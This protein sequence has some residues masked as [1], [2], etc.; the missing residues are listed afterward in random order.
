MSRDD[1]FLEDILNS[2][3]IIREYLSG[4]ALESFLANTEKQD[5]VNRRFEIMGEATRHLSP[6]VRQALPEIP[7]TLM[8]GMRNILIHDYDEVDPKRVWETAQND[9]PTLISRLEKYLA[10]ASPID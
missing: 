4:V 2:A 9:L 8:T 10:D 1:T 5:A 3:R 6:S 7:W